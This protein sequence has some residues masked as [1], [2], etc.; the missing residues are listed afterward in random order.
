MGYP[1]FASVAPG[2]SDGAALTAGAAPREADSTHA[3]AADLSIVGAQSDRRDRDVMRNHAE[4][5]TG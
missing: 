2:S 5:P 1:I 3:P 4:Q